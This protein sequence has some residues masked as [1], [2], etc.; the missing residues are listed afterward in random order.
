MV[1]LFFALLVVLPLG[2]LGVNPGFRA[3]IT[4]KGLTYVC[5]TA[6]VLL[7][8]ALPSLSIP[9]IN[10]RVK[11][12]VVFIKTSIDYSV[13]NI[14]LGDLTIPSCN[15]VPS[16]DGLTLSSSGISVQITAHVRAEHKHFPHVSASTD[17]QINLDDVSF[18]TTAKLGRDPSD[19]HATV[20]DTTCSGDV[21]AV[22]VSFHGSAAWLYRLFDHEFESMLKS[23]F[24]SAFCSQ[25]M[26]ELNKQGNAA[27]ES[28]PLVSKFEDFAVINYT[29]TQDPEYTDSYM[30]VFMKGEF[31]A[32][33]KTISIPFSPPTLP[34]VQVE[35]GRML[36]IWLT[37]YIPNTAGYVLQQSGWLEYTITPKLIPPSAPISLNTSSFKQWVPSLFDHFPNMGM[38]ITLKSTKPPTIH[39]TSAGGQL[40]AFGSI[41]FDV[42]LPNNTVVTA[43]TL[44][45]ST[46]MDFH[47]QIRS[48]GFTGITANVS[49]A[50]ASITL[51]SSQIGKFNANLLKDALQFA[52][53][54]FVIPKINQY[55]SKGIMIPTID[56]ISFMN[57]QLTFGEGYALL[58][59]DIDYKSPA[60]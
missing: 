56:G 14:K 41:N 37:D 24:H 26:K 23:K 10:G 15:F 29:L 20:T 18:S 59:T 49:L 40:A 39:V 52:L 27:L 22:H 16:A 48:D 35:G 53:K 28:L 42:V 44:G 51:E 25:V 1:S 8:R 36:Y 13:S 46:D 32:I 60:L 17:I 4:D 54:I 11:I 38:Q 12:K 3:A 45:L 6:T 50:S 30:A 31:Q 9:D 2:S 57:P 7:E 55:T 34:P 47:A 58:S 33:D 19:G 21:G 5:H 43:F